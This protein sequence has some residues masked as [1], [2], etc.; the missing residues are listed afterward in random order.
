MIGLVIA[1]SGGM[2]VFAEDDEQDVETTLPGVLVRYS[3]T[4]SKTGSAEAVVAVPRLFGKAGQSPHLGVPANGFHVEWSGVLLIPYQGQYTLTARRQT[5]TD[6]SIVIVD[7]AIAFG[8]PV[9][10]S[11]GPVPFII[12]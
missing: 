11:Q 2:S 6:L 4:G 12:R 9:E 8:T 1:C 10:L 3:V 7:Q 5:L